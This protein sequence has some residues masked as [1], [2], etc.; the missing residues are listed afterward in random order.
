MER[1]LRIAVVIPKYGLTGGAEG[2]AAELT[3]R[4]ARNPRY[5]FH[6]FAN[7]WIANSDRITFHK[8]PIVTFPKFLTT[9]SFAWFVKK[10][11]EKTPFDLIHTHER[12]FRADIF[13]M[14]GVPHRFWVRDVRRKRVMSLYDAATDWTERKLVRSDACRFFLPVSTLTE[15]VFLETYPIDRRKVRVIHPGIHLQQGGY[16]PERRRRARAEIGISQQEAL[17]LFVS[18][19]FEIKG[20]D[21]LL[22][23]LAVLRSRGPTENFKLLVVGKGDE[24]KYRALSRTLRIDDLVLFTGQLTRERMEEIYLAADIY[25]MLSRFDTFG[26]VVLEAM[27]AGLPVVVSTNVGARDLVIEGENGFV[28]EKVGDAEE[29]A[30][31]IA[32]LLDENIRRRMGEK[33]LETALSHTWEAV[34]AD[35][36]AIYAETLYEQMPRR[37]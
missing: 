36:E 2:F 23:A 31:K 6:V 32:L 4:L 24:R 19:N 26:M 34:A 7:R 18:M 28:V 20:L 8:V 5:E 3:G 30:D 14:H 35:V 11:T 33:A 9:V 16:D 12:I 27:A 13:T 37:T 22:K 10:M 29:V 15:E 17:I 25:A 21:H 1:P